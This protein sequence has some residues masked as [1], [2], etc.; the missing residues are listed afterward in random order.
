MKRFN[1]KRFITK[2]VAE[3]IS[4]LLQIIMWQYIDELSLPKDYLQVFDL[5]IENGKQKI[6]HT[7]RKKNNK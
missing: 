1:N 7:C 3:N 5:T 4:P 2:G 6:K